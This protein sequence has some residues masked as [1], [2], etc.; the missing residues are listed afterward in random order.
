MSDRLPRVSVG[1]AVYNGENYIRE[2]IDSILAQTFEDFELIISDNA[3]TDKTQEICLEYAARDQRIR[4]DRADRNRG[5]AW[6]QNR[7][8]ELS[9]GTYYKLAAHD[10]V[11]APDY[12]AKC[13]AVLDQNPAVVLCHSWT[14][15]INE[16]SEIVEDLGDGSFI[17]E[18]SK[19]KRLV[20]GFI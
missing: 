12:L 9:T 19:L 14:R 10:D 7:V 16:K 1:L 5:A 18:S 2:A 8:F 3:S 13:V 4:Y 17:P 20:K 11:I 15:S 6:N